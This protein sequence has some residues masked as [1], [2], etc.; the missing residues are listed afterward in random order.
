MVADAL[1]RKA[2]R[3]GSL[4]FIPDEETPL[5]MDI[6]ALANRFVRLDI[7]EP[8][9]VFT[10]VVAQSSLLEGIKVRQYDDPHLLVLK[11]TIQQDGAKKVVIEN[12]DVMIIQGNLCVPNANGLRELIHQETQ[13]LQYYIHPGTTMMYHNLN[14]HYW[15]RRMKKDIVGHVSQYLNCQKVKYVYQKPGGLTRGSVLLWT[16]W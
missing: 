11:D 15:W 6:Q 2:K 16:S 1:S 3:M 13:S 10:Y 12:D 8:S 14:K 5:A 9:R 4:V 7:S